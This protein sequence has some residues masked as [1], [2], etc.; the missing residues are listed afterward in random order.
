M[1][2]Y[3]GDRRRGRGLPPDRQR[4]RAEVDALADPMLRF[5]AAD[6]ER[7]DRFFALTGLSPA[8]IRD[9]ADGASFSGDLL[10]YVSSDEA[11]LLAFAGE[12]GV[13]P[14][15]LAMLREAIAATPPDD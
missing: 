7:L 13:E 11:L 15:R 5:L 6:S 14:A 12:S 9:A 1:A 2:N 4:A 10:D 3:D 8:S